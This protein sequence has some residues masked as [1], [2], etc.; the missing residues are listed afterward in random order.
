MK[1]IT[2]KQSVKSA[3][4]AF[5]IT[6]FAIAAQAQTPFYSVNGVGGTGGG[7][8]GITVTPTIAPT[9]SSTLTDL[10][11]TANLSFGTGPNGVAGESLVN[12]ATGQAGNQVLAGTLGAS[13]SLS[14]FTVTMWVNQSAAVNNNYRILELAPSAP[15]TTGS[16]DGTKL[17][18]GLNSGG[19]LQFY[20][21]NV[22]GN[23]TATDIATAA[24]WNN[25]GTLGA[26][27][28]GKWYFE[29]V[30]YDTVAGSALLYSGDQGDSATLAYTYG[31]NVTT[32]GNLDI[33]TNTAIALL[34][35]FANGRNYPG[36]IDDVNIY[37][38]ALNQSQ[39]DSIQISEV[40]E[41]TTL[42][43]LGLGSLA[44][45]ITVRRRRS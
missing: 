34:D 36:A 4:C 33:S 1:Q 26:L 17:F 23:S 32:A 2:M 25:G 35:R 7:S 38:G 42:A 22:N 14:A 8:S 27:T 45:I 44:G 5:A 30:T 15:A 12:A 28:S 37:S 3:L 40:P 13:S 18:L 31:A 19:G 6:G 20:A 39:L 29:A 21:N 41:P 16:P 11:A 43:M 9:G 10:G 24:T